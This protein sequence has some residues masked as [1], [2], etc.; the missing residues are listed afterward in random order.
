VAREGRAAAGIP[1]NRDGAS[2]DEGVASGGRSTAQ[3]LTTKSWTPE[4]NAEDP[5]VVVGIIRPRNTTASGV[6]RSASRPRR[7][8]K[9]TKGPSRQYLCPRIWARQGLSGKRGKEEKESRSTAGFSRVSADLS[10]QPE[11]GDRADIKGPLV[12]YWDL[13]P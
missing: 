12:L 1:E 11:L 10:Q 8:H 2:E 9:G 5:A 4:S 3:L 7:M 6:R 13:H